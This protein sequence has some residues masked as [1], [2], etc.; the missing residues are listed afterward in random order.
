MTS[1]QKKI[2]E[3]EIILLNIKDIVEIT[4]WCEATVRKM[5]V[6]NDFPAIK[7]GKEYKVEMYAFRNYLRSSREN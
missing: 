5:F 6:S 2:V 1:E 7:N 3:K 4:G